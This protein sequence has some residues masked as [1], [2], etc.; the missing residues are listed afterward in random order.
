MAGFNQ[1]ESV[2]SSDPFEEFEFRPI[3]EGLGFHRK[4]KSAVQSLSSF[5]SG[6][7]TTRSLPTR[8]EAPTFSTP[9]PKAQ[10][11]PSTMF[12]TPLPRN[13]RLDTPTSRN[14]FN[15]PSIED[16]SIAKAQTAV[17]EI[18]KNLNQKRQFDFV[19]ET[20]KTRMDL[21]KSKPIFFAATLDGM[22]ITAAFLMSMI[23]MLTV[24][25]IDLFLNLSR[26]ETAGP[27]YLATAGLLLSVA[28]IYMLVNRTF[29]GYTPGEWAFDQRCGT[30]NQMQ[31]MSYVP[32]LAFRTLLVIATGFV[33]LPLL[34]YLFN[35]DI[36][37]QITG[38]NLFR[39][40]NA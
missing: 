32:R 21:K 22:L 28:F 35:K 37:G 25:K 31:S 3:N 15:I 12:T 14:S 2:M 9:P 39:R 30:E 34:S 36:A 24:T 7:T 8:T 17:N 26:A 20:E 29:L 1:K 38:V 40:P 23:V 27:L 13:E 6:F 19:N 5:D 18:L 4:Q 10:L 11:G 16:D 33:I